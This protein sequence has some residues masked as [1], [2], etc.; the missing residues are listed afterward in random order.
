MYKSQT[1]QAKTN[2]QLQSTVHFITLFMPEAVSDKKKSEN[3]GAQPTPTRLE[4]RMKEMKGV[5]KKR[6][7]KNG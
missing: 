5:R 3:S 1:T 4:G 2:L 6:G 7:K